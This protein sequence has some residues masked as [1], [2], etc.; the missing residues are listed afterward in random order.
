MKKVIIF[1]YLIQLICRSGAQP[2]ILLDS[3]VNTTCFSEY[4]PSISFDGKTL[5]FETDRTGDWK[6]FETHL[7]N[8]NTWTKPE[9]IQKVNNTG[10]MSKF[11]GGVFLTYDNNYLYFS[12]DMKGTEGD[13]DIW[14]SKR[15]EKGWG[16]PVNIGV[17]VNSEYFDGFPS[18]TADGNTIYF[19]RNFKHGSKPDYY[20][21]GYYIYLSQKNEDGTWQEPRLL[22]EPVNGFADECPRI[23][24]DGKTLVFSSIRPGGAGRYDLYI[25]ELQRD[26]TWSQPQ[27]LSFANTGLDDKLASVSASGDIM[28]YT[29]QTD[30]VD[31]I[32]S[33]KLTEKNSF[34]RMLMI[35]GIVADKE[36]RNPVSCKLFVF[37]NA[38]GIIE[39]D[40]TSGKDGRYSIFIPAGKEYKFSVSHKDFLPY[41]D[42]L[43]LY[44]PAENII[45]KNI[46]LL[47]NTLIVK[48][49]VS[50]ADTHEPLP[51]EIII[52][53][54]SKE[55]RL[56]VPSY[57]EGKY[58][59]SLAIGKKYIF[60]VKENHYYFYTG[61]LDL[62]ELKHYG[63]IIKNIEL[64]PVRH[65][66]V[67]GRISDINTNKPLSAEI[68]ITRI[69]D[70][71]PVCEITSNDSGFYSSPVSG[72]DKY[73][74][75]VFPEGYMFYSKS[76]ELDSL[77]RDTVVII[78]AALKPIQKEVA[79]VLNNIQ[80]K[81]DSY[82]LL[83]QSFIELDKVVR[84]MTTN[85]EISIELSAHTC[86]LGSNSYNLKLSQK[87]AEVATQYLINKGIS[88]NRIISKGYGETRPMVQNISEENRKI[89]RRVE[90][91]IK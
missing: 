81:F 2:A 54:N 48:G 52:E 14:Y 40:T 53:D 82:I 55:V 16:K 73:E 57:E 5:I 10:E 35:K 34:R 64:I 78:D 62:S 27:N 76:F 56:R 74:L 69:K 85:A 38:D 18:L 11:M 84:L 70:N 22:P 44:N 6:I 20:R 77:K 60:S 59:T 46:E 83:P 32:Y 49:L 66:E 25:T 67:R 41:S 87:R 89:N 88:N 23:M 71:A 13:V 31:D 90:F 80:F 72:K 17:P 37:N 47:K 86:D 19:M 42:L 65:A 58:S 29:I 68:T 43:D 21:T 45:E 24:P 15:F 1:I 50:N 3:T 75:S 28:Y 63:E 4:S 61:Q 30:S 39:T 9:Y 36:T 26:K 33:I 51:V 91:R 8:D 79:V 12:S 7:K